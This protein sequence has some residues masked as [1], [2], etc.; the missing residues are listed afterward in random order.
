MAQQLQPVTLDAS[1]EGKLE[2]PVPAFNGEL[3]LMAQVWSEDSFGAA[4]R[5]MV[6]AAPLVSE[7]ATP[8]FLASGD[9]STLALDLTNLTD[10]P[11]TLNVTV[12]ASGLIALNGQI[13]AGA[14]G[15]RGADHAG[16]PG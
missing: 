7:L 9:Q 5:K 15:E 3:R 4:D 10:Q 12:N 11:Q 1:G 2:L 6:V 8:R 13:P 14:A 16:D